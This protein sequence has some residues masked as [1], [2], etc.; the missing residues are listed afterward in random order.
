MIE[1]IL[2]ADDGVPAVNLY[3][4]DPDH[5]SRQVRLQLSRVEGNQSVTGTKPDVAVMHPDAVDLTRRQSIAR[6]I[7]LQGIAVV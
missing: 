2:I 4:F 1:Y 5:R 3:P 6:T 7:T